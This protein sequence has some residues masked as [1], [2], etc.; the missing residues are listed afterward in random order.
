MFDITGGQLVA[1]VALLIPI[2]AIVMNGVVKMR[3]RDAGPG[4]SAEAERALMERADRLNERVA[5]LETILDAESPG[6]RSRAS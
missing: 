5:Q 3:E 4:L 2:T 6:W 1:I